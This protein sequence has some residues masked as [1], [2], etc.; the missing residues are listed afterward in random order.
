M[1]VWRWCTTPPARRERQKRIQTG[2]QQGH[3]QALNT[4]AT[5]QLQKAGAEAPAFRTIQNIR[6]CFRP[7]NSLASSGVEFSGGQAVGQRGV[8][9][10]ASSGAS[11]S[12]FLGR[13]PAGA[14]GAVGA[15]EV[16]FGQFELLVVGSLA[17]NVLGAFFGLDG[18]TGSGDQGGEAN[19]AQSNFFHGTVPIRA[20]PV[21]M[22]NLDPVPQKWVRFIP[23]PKQM[24][25]ENFKLFAIYA[26]SAFSR[27]R[28][29][30]LKG[31]FSRGTSLRHRL[32][33][34]L[35][36]C[37]PKKC[38]RQQTS[39]FE[40]LSNTHLAGAP[41]IALSASLFSADSADGVH[42]G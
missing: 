40:R 41:W 29:N 38:A 12:S 25:S 11:V 37:I 31:C 23:N 27:P 22:G 10:F 18:A 3:L 19:E 30:R 36:T 32:F 24:P 5:P 35:G 8:G 17:L 7:S 1:Q 4:K 21:L 34:I 13:G 6:R 39:V 14:F 33:W 15:G 20:N 2:I 28:S 26:V 42:A 16:G 9:A